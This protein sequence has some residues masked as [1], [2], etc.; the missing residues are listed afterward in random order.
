MLD[1]ADY[2]RIR[3]V[4]KIEGK[5]QRQASETLGHSR[6]TIA[7]ALAHSSPPGYRR[8]TPPPRPALDRFLSIIDAWVAAD[9]QQPRKQRHTGTRIYERL[10]DEYGFTGSISAVRRYLAQRKKTQGEV[11]FPLQFEVGEEGQV[12]WGEAWCLLNGV[13]QKVFLFCLRLCYSSVSYVR[14]YYQESQECFQDGHVH[15]FGFLG[16]VPRR[17]AYDNLKSAVITVGQGQ[18][19]HLNSH[20]VAL[21]S[22]YLFET[23]FCNVASGNEKG[24]VEN[25][26]K[27]SQRTFMTPL[28]CIASLEALNAHLEAQCRKEWDKKAPRREETR[29][30]LLEEERDHFLELPPAPFAACRQ[31]STFAN[32]QST[33]RFDT[34][35]YSLPVRWAHHPVQ[36][37][38]FVDQIEIWTGQ[39]RVATHLRS[40]GRYQYVLDPFHY[41]PLLEKKPGG[42][43]HGRPFK[44]APWGEDFACMRRELEYRYGGEGTRKYIDILLLFTGYPVEAVHQAVSL[45]VKRRA[46]SDEAVQS[47]LDYQPPALSTTL[48]LSDRPDF[49][50]ESTGIRPA[51]EYDVLLPE[52]GGA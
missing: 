45:C 50:V 4:V 39:Q 19:R 12:D 40:Y 3:R 42:I 23:R 1:V 28:P 10:R 26:V 20:F 37:K 25:L 31:Q 14:A 13:E 49:Q 11:F 48:D 15:A 8:Q 6:K 2:E 30:G 16:G 24:H 44:G 41:I 38:G 47:I 46:F 9:R 22:H 29:G 5:T 17:L 43:H 51:R 35:D 52:E 33:V 18:D 32:K 7:K 36:V 27:H 34:N 21:R